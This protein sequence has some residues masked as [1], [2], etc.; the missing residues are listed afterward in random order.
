VR[1]LSLIIALGLLSSSAARAEPWSQGRYGHNRVVHLSITAVSG[2][3]FIASETVLKSH[4]APAACRW[5]EPDSLDARIRNAV[6]WSNPDH[7]SLASNLSGFVVAPVFGLGLA[8]AGALTSEDPTTAR[9]LDDTIPILE[10]VTLSQSL[11]QIVKFSVGRARPYAHFDAPA[12]HQIDDDLS[13]FSGHSAL[14]FGIATSAGLI[15]H[16]RHSWTEP[17]IWAGG[18][19]L[20]AAT[21]YLR[22]AADKHY[23][24]DVLT[25]SAIGVL[26]GLTVPSLMC[27]TGSEA[28]AVLPTGNGVAISGA[29]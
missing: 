3:W 4:L 24:T 16:R 18:M 6:V 11:S 2:A 29:F 17:Y 8:I 7:A 10:T 13:F 19:T 14:T 21:A 9:V 25:G 22:M 20:A 12:P 27:R 5:C 26:A 28:I 1:A 15:A 23:F